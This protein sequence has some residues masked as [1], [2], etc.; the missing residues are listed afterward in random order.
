MWYEG[1]GFRMRALRCI[2]MI[3]F[4]LAWGW[5]ALGAG[6]GGGGVL[7]ERGL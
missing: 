1:L 2:F 5:G 3:G 4:G 6:R 7:G